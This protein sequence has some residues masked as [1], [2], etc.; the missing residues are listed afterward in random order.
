MPN[1]IPELKIGPIVERGSSMGQRFRRPRTGLR[2]S[3][4]TKWG[5][6]LLGS[7]PV[8]RSLASTPGRPPSSARGRHSSRPSTA[9]IDHRNPAQ[10]RF[11]QIKIELNEPFHDMPPSRPAPIE[12]DLELVHWRVKPTPSVHSAR[13]RVVSG[14]QFRDLEGFEGD[15]GEY[16][17]LIEDYEGSL[18]GLSLNN[19]L[20][21]YRNESA[22]FTSLALFI[23]TKLREVQYATRSSP[24]PNSFRTAVICDMMLKLSTCLGGFSEAFR[25]IVVEMIKSIYVEIDLNRAEPFRATPFFVEKRRIQAAMAAKDQRIHNLQVEVDYHKERS[26]GNRVGIDGVIKNWQSSIVQNTF[27]QWRSYV[28]QRKDKFL[29]LSKFFHKSNAVKDLFLRWKTV[30]SRS[31]SIKLRRLMEKH[32]EMTGGFEERLRAVTEERDLQKIAFLSCLGKL[33]VAE[34]D[35]LQLRQQVAMTT[36]EIVHDMKDKMTSFQINYFRYAITL[37]GERLRVARESLIGLF[38]S[39]WLCD[40]LQL[41]TPNDGAISDHDLLALVPEDLVLRWT[42][43]RLRSCKEV[44]IGPV[45]DLSASFQSGEVLVVLMYLIAPTMVTLHSLDDP[46]PKER[47]KDALTAAIDI[48][49]N[50]GPLAMLADVFENKADLTFVLLSR[51]MAMFP[52]V[53]PRKQVISAELDE[54]DSVIHN[55]ERLRRSRKG[56]VPSELESFTVLV[57]QVVAKSSEAVNKLL[58]RHHLW[59]DIVVK[60]SGLSAHMLAA[61]MRGEPIVVNDARENADMAQYKTMI[62]NKIE[63]L[64]P[65]ALSPQEELAR[66]Q[67][68]LDKYAVANR[69]IF[70]HYA[71][72]EGVGSTMSINEFVKFVQDAKLVGKTLKLPQVERIFAQANSE[73]DGTADEAESEAEEEEIV[74]AEEYDD[75]VANPDEELIPREFVECL[76]RLAIKKYAKP[77]SVADRLVLLMETF[78]LKN[79]MRS[80]RFREELC[81]VKVKDVFDR[82]RACLKCIFRYYAAGG[83][84]PKGKR[85]TAQDDSMSL[86]EFKLMVQ[87][88]AWVDATFSLSHVQSIFNNIQRT[89]DEEASEVNTELVYDEFIEGIAAIAVMKIPNPYVEIDTRIEDFIHTR[90]LAPLVKLNII[91]GLKKLVKTKASIETP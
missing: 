28:A 14:G 41:I 71:A 38:Q 29:K 25:P 73:G 44:K 57:N 77:Y 59:E 69:R 8:D 43:L 18:T 32:N 9:P 61:R 17:T 34:A 45:D 10:R 5:V 80:E 78:V 33:D 52:G 21:T 48:G 79:A 85:K 12:G 23:E 27:R 51:L 46:D 24:V 53:H 4:A 74:E 75:A 63:K 84:K 49:A 67:I 64:I 82:N 62:W 26:A 55:W 36:D 6:Q 2:S 31:A 47:I 3:G 58:K 91:T 89:D 19:W 22:M 65:S 1:V 76:L 56:R 20:S 40:A 50:P 90:L 83:K 81:S 13:K 16:M 39:E 15:D 72:G 42:N 11:E 7:C 37:I 54:L 35:L 66:I 68:Q 86:A 87:E 70:R 30:T 60:V 88:C